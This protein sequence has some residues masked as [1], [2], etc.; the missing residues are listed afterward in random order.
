MGFFKKEKP[1]IDKG[2]LFRIAK[3]AGVDLEK[4]F[5]IVGIRARDNK[6][7][8]YDDAI[9]IVSKNLC[10]SFTAN[11]DPGAYKKGIAN[12]KAGNWLYKIGIHGLSKPKFLQYTALAQADVVTVARDEKGLDTGL[13]GI[14]IH[15]GGYNSVSSLG[16]QTIHP[17]QWKE[18]IET[19]KNCTA[20]YKQKTIRYALR[21]VIDDN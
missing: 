15:K 2:L 3:E 16:C 18:F 19:V 7:A 1:N 9:F 5:C 20:R 17:S 13:F 21:D 6:R 10:K 8:I 4:E 12:L 11:C 14:N